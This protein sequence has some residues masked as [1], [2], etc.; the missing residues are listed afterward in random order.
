PTD[1]EVAKAKQALL[2]S[3]I[4][5]ADSKRKIL[6][7]QITYEYFGYPL[8]W[9]SRYRA[10]VEAVTVAQVRAA[11]AKYLH[12]EQ[13]EIVVVGPATG[14]DKPLS[15]YGAVTPLDVTIERPTPGKQ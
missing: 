12:P 10:G 8:D 11:A 4:F 3:F 15:T 1:E 9:L 2:N 6:S 13:F 7:Q 5:Q 14:T